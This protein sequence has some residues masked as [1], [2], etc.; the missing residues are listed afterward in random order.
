MGGRGSQ[1]VWDGRVHTT[2]FKIDDQEGRVVEHREL[3]SM[4][5]GSLHGRGVWGRMDK[6][7]R[8]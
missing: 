2:I 3:C 8:I 6:C 1:R 4:L 5:C 7:I